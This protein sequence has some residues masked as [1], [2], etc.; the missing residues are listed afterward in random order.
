MLLTG[1]LDSL[2]ANANI[3]QFK[4]TE[5]LFQVI[6]EAKS[7]HPDVIAVNYDPTL[8][9]PARIALDF[10]SWAADHEI[11][12]D[13]AMSWPLIDSEERT[14]RLARIQPAHRSG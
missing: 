1:R 6:R 4:S 13:P 9:F 3:A 12:Y 14:D 11:T 8:K 5:Q 10:I 2:I 7:N